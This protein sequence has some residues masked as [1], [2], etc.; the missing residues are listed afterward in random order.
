[1]T[2]CT[3]HMATFCSC[4]FKRDTLAYKLGA[5]VKRIWHARPRSPRIDFGDWVP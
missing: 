2:R 1:M 5:R 3:A 4:R